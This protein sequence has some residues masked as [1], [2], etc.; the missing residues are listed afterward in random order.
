MTKSCEQNFIQK[1]V[2]NGSRD[3]KRDKK[4][5][6]TQMKMLELAERETERL[7]KRNKLNELQKHLANIEKRLGVLHERFKI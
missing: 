1:P 5:N 7:L 2:Q 6:N 4:L 3:F